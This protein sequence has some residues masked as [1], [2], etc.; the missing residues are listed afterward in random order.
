MATIS[1]TIFQMLCISIQISLKLV[2]VRL[3]DNKSPLY[4]KY[5][6]GENIKLSLHFI[7]NNELSN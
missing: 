4:V 3:I 7:G 6:F 2:P 5:I 1:Q